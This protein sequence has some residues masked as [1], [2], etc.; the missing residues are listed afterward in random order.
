[1]RSL[2]I[3]AALVPVA[4]PAKEPASVENCREKAGKI[5]MLMKEL[6]GGEWRVNLQRDFVMI[7]KKI[8]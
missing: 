2:A 5:A 8:P 4:S 6:F 1:M 3:A 7:S